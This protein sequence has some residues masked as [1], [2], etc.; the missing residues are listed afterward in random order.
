MQVCILCGR[1]GK[2]HRHLCID[3]YKKRYVRFHLPE[4]I[5]LT[6]CSD[7]GAAKLGERWV[8]AGGM[9]KAISRRIEQEFEMRGEVRDEVSGEKVGTNLEKKDDRNWNAT[10]CVSIKVGE[11][12]I[13]DELS[14]KI[15]IRSGVCQRCSKKHGSYFEA[16]LQVRGHK[17]LS[18]AQLDMIHDFVAGWAERAQKEDRD[19]FIGKEE[20]VAGG[21][22]FYLSGKIAGRNLAKELMER[23][24]GEMTEAPKLYGMKKGKELYRMTYL[25]R[26]PP[27]KD[28]DFIFFKGKAYRISGVGKRNVT[29]LDMSSWKK[30]VADRR[31]LKDV[32]ILG[33]DEVL[34]E[35]V[36][37]S[38]TATEIQIMDPD[39]YKTVELRKSK[40]F[41][42]KD[43]TVRILK[44]HGE[45]HLMFEE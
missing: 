37:L 9:E 15:R 21:I 31:G 33:G 3:C 2:L 23:S 38:Q 40:D 14:S 1:S 36:V 19:F 11:F 30:G 42:V 10:V 24:G 27:Y 35:A 26:L 28:G 22:D 8:D 16:I 25:V 34:K 18:G 20:E 44:V 32:E 29:L 6:I 39:T 4:Y 7:C 13:G 12:D 43:E 45:T 17:R 5:D 41:K